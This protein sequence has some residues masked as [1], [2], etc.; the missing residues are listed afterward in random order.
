MALQRIEPITCPEWMKA[1]WVEYGGALAGIQAYKTAHRKLMRPFWLIWWAAGIVAM[2]CNIYLFIDSKF[3]TIFS[4]ISL[5]AILICMNVGIAAFIVA[6]VR[7]L[8]LLS[9]YCTH[10]YR[11]LRTID[12]KRD[13]AKNKRTPEEESIVQNEAIQAVAELVDEIAAYNRGVSRW[14]GVVGDKNEAGVTDNKAIQL[15]QEDLLRLRARLEARLFRAEALFQVSNGVSVTPT[16]FRIEDYREPAAEVHGEHEAVN[17]VLA[18][19]EA[20]GALKLS[21][22]HS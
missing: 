22:G 15:V 9:K 1:R 21:A 4:F 2:L 14:R 11:D 10:W 12:R 3:T 18:G 5:Y 7:E 6:F 17:E 8:M 19:V 16:H 20:V 13:A